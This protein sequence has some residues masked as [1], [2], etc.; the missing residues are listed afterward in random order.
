MN[1][2]SMKEDIAHI[3]GLHESD[4]PVT[5]AVYTITVVMNEEYPEGD[6]TTKLKY[7]GTSSKQ[8]WMKDTSLICV[9]TP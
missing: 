7:F 8:C 1:I 5:A 9:T 2:E 6:T 4:Y 3:T